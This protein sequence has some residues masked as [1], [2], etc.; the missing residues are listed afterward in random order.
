MSHV[1]VGSSNCNSLWENTVLDEKENGVFFYY[2][3]I[4]QQSFLKVSSHLNGHFFA[5][6]FQFL[7]VQQEG[8]PKVKYFVFLFIFKRNFMVYNLFQEVLE[9]NWKYQ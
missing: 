3:L 9:N 8:T 6:T 1:R 2:S 5:E 7:L 4:S